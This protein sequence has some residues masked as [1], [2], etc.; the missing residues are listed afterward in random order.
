M[1]ALTTS[2]GGATGG[3]LPIVPASLPAW[4]HLKMLI[5]LA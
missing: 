1:P 3:G 5:G 2:F 4:S